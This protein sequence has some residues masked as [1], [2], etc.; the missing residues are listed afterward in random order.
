[1]K[2]ILKQKSQDEQILE[3]LKR[4]TKRIEEVTVDIHSI[5]F[6]VK[7]TKLDVGYIQSDLAIM[8][9][10]IEKIREELE[11]AEERLG[12]RISNVAD[13]MTISLGQKFGKIEKRIRKIEQVQQAS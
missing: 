10:D 12:K 5:K 7:E 11:E 4:L 8:K 2:K 1:M 9:V 13:L 6:D 3:V